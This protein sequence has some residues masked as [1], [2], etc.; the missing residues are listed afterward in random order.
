[1]DVQFTDHGTIWLAKPLTPAGEAWIEEHIP[2]EAHWCCGAV[3]IEPR[4]V[5]DIAQGMADD[6]LQVTNE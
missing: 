1:M 5:G 4:Y 2:V 6:G 3:V